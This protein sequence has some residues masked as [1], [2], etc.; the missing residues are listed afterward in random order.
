MDGCIA[1][2]DEGGA[3]GVAMH[4]SD[5]ELRAGDLD[6][7]Q[8]TIDWALTI[9]DNGQPS[10]NL[11]MYLAFAALIAAHRGGVDN[12]RTL[13]ERI[14]QMTELVGEPHSI[15]AHRIVAGHLELS[16]GNHAAALDWLEPTVGIFRSIGYVEPGAYFFLPD[17]LEALIA[18]GRHTE[19]ERDITE[20]ETIGRRYDR[21]F[22][23]ATGARAR[24]MLLAAQ[25]RVTQAEPAFA[26]ALAHHQRLDW[27]HQHGRTLLAYGQTLRRTG[28][29]RDARARLEAALEIFDRIDEP[30]WANQ[31][32]EE[33]ARLGGRTP[34]GQRLTDGE[35]RVVE[36]VAAGRSNREVATELSVTV[37]TVEAVLTR[38]YAKLNVR[39]R[40]ELAANWSALR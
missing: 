32:R 5:A 30:L 40:A 20:W 31:A 13:V 33:M 15:S 24:G 9:A 16:L 36:L 25:G 22:P 6:R 21:P 29:R 18:V 8:A 23:L 3:C 7:A 28:R 35:R 11:S 34:S 26:E 2:G 17:R 1:R 37:K 27:P 14:R 12:A 4:L 38:A 10:Q 39:S 19:A